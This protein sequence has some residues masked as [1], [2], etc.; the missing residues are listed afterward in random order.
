MP[1]PCGGFAGRRHA[2]PSL[3]P[4]ARRS[5]AAEAWLFLRWELALQGPVED[6]RVC[7]GLPSTSCLGSSNRTGANCI[8]RLF[9]IPNSFSAFPA[10][11]RELLL[12][13]FSSVPLWLPLS[14][15]RCLSPR[16]PRVRMGHELPV[17]PGA[18]NVDIG[19]CPVSV[20]SIAMANSIHWRVKQHEGDNGSCLAGCVRVGCAG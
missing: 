5:G 20:S 2:A 17:S 13:P 14:L 9:K 19:R 12:L 11:P 18:I 15:C 1:A 3:H 16:H 8:S 7:T 4:P 10:S 6:I